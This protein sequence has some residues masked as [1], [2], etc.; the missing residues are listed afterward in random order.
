MCVILTWFNALNDIVTVF[1]E[2]QD[3]ARIRKEDNGFVI[4]VFMLSLCKTFNKAFKQR[5]LLVD[6][7]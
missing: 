5:L 7:L 6:F 1:L 2:E 4:R 3:M